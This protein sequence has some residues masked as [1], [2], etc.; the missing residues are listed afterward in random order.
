MNG[1]KNWW[2]NLTAFEKVSTIIIPILVVIIVVTAIIIANKSRALEELKRKNDEITQ[3]SHF[4]EVY[5]TNQ[6]SQTTQILEIYNL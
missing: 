1:L 5:T 3:T 2:K 4:S 6:S